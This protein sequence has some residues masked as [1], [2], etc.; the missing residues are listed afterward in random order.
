MKKWKGLTVKEK[1]VY[2]KLSLKTRLDLN[3]EKEI[4]D[5]IG[6]T[7]LEPKDR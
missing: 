6:V 3:T 2:K 4:L 1:N 5:K 7:Y